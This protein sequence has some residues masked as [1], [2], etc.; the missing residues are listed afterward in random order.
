MFGNVCV[1]KPLCEAASEY[2]ERF[3]L[4]GDLHTRDN[5][6]L[7]IGYR[8][9]DGGSGGLRDRGLDQKK[10]ETEHDQKL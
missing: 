1:A 8:A 7:R 2:T 3:R 9:F 4:R 5:A 6:A 10:S